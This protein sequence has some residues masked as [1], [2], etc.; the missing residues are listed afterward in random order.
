[1]ITRTFFLLTII[2]L[3]CTIQVDPA[4]GDQDTLALPDKNYTIQTESTGNKGITEPTG[5]F[6]PDAEDLLPLHN[7]MVS[8]ELRDIPLREVLY[9]IAESAGLNLIIERG[10]NTELPL[11]L[12]VKNISAEDA[13]QIILDAAGYFYRRKG[14]ILFVKAL[15]TIVFEFGQPAIVQNYSVEVGGDI[16]GSAIEGA[17]SFSGQGGGGGSEGSGDQDIKGKV[18]QRITS[19][20][21]AFD[22]WES[23]EQAIK[24]ILDISDSEQQVAQGDD[25]RPFFNISRMTGTISVTANKDGLERVEQYLAFLKKALNRQVIIEARV[26]EVKLSEGLQY[27]F[28]WSWLASD[29]VTVQGN[30]FSSVL[31]DGSPNIQVNITRGDFSGVVRAIESQGKVKVLSNP[32]IN[33][34]NGQTAL[35]SVGRSQSFLSSIESDI[36]TGDNPV[37]T[38]TTDTASVLTGVMIGIVPYIN[39]KG[40]IAMSITPIISELIS[41]DERPVGE[42]G[43]SISLPTVDLRQLSTTVKVKDGEMIVIGGLVQTR[44]RTNDNKVPFIGKVPLIGYLF[45][46]FD[47]VDEQTDI[48]ILLKPTLTT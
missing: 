12:S 46:R 13:L 24:N 43:T 23:I 22:F 11:T 29:S 25:L 16:L 45:T 3:L 40:E 27:G 33:I 42:Q 1:M 34:M 31:G 32:R 10:V 9:S 20:K 35:L 18:E 19:D 41:L 14:N 6:L 21:K 30:N 8:I 7:K 47:D 4:V 2:T 39:E 44:K 38:F 48:I 26:M 28:D 37:I 5:E 17:Q 15:D 36:T